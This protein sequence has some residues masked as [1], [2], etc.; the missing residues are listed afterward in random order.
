M[1]MAS[2]CVD[3]LRSRTWWASKASAQL[4]TTPLKTH[5]L[6]SGTFVELSFADSALGYSQTALSS[7]FLPRG[8]ALF[9]SRVYTQGGLRLRKSASWAAM[10]CFSCHCRHL[11]GKAFKA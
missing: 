6:T 4:S 10:L 3:L 7:I 1:T 9:P 8:S 5:K 11:W 2:A